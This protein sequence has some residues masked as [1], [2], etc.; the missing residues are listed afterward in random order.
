MQMARNAKAA[1]CI[2]I[3]WVGKSENVQGADVVINQ[4]GEIQI[5]EA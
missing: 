5:L 3:T 1:G 2:G 4:L